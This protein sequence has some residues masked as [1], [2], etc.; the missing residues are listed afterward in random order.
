M[1]LLLRAEPEELRR[2]PRLRHAPPSRDGPDRVQPTAR[3][4]AR[5]LAALRGLHR[6]VV[7][8][9]HGSAAERGGT[10]IE[11]GPYPAG[12]PAAVGAD[13]RGAPPRRE[14][15]GLPLDAP[16]VLYPGD[17][18]LGDG[19]ARIVEA[20]AAMGDRDA[21]LVMACRP[22]TA[23]AERAEVELRERA[24]A[25]GI[26]DRVTWIGETPRIHDLIAAADV[27]ALPSTDSYAKMDLPLVLLEA[28]WLA[29][30]VVVASGA[31]AA[32]LADGGGALAVEPG[33]LAATLHRLLG[34][35]AARDALG[36]T[37]RKVANDRF[38]PD[39]MAA[40]YETLYDRLLEERP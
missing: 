6:R 28:M 27:V 20:F 5:P 1:A 13:R 31:P 4:H 32:E 14:D 25:H 40:A 39:R 35:D 16:L 24:R 18:E 8:R 38:T 10:R 21:R 26:T 11:A 7:P 30:P 19:A 23:D 3:A 15:L 17:L 9:Q 29:R 34:D 37:A 12:R 36:R 2:R 33:A 22:K